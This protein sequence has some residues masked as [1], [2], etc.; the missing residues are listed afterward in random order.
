MG[1]LNCLS[2][3]LLQEGWTKDQIPPGCCGEWKDY[4]GGWEYDGKTAAAMT[5]ET[6]CGLLVNSAHWMNGH[7]AFMGMEWT[8]EN[9]NPT[10]TCPRFLPGPCPMNHPLLQGQALM[11]GVER[12]TICACHR[13]ERPYTYEGSVDEA[14]DQVWAEADRLFEEFDRAKGGRACKQQSRYNR[15]TRQ[16]RMEYDPQ[17]C[18][19]LGV[20]RWCKVLQTEISPKK[21]NVFYD[22]KT[23]WTEP[24]EG[25]FQ[26]E[27][28]TMV[29]KG[30]KL[31]EKP[32]SMTL[33][34]AI[35]KYGRHRV[36]RNYHL[37]RHNELFCNPTVKIEL[38]NFR[39]ARMDVRDLIQD[40]QDVRDGIEVRHQADDTKA[41]KEQKRKR[42]AAAKAKKLAKLEARVLQ[43][44]PALE[45]YVLD[46]AF[47]LLGRERV[48]ELLEQWEEPKPKKAE[49]EQLSL[50]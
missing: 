20:C 12:L 46:R 10:V 8:V 31:L 50:L 32:V 15:T 2:L 11:G 6:P 36:I 25:L 1:Q 35:V 33:C 37:S 5:F 18:A 49:Y 45:S 44:G 16:W 28:R 30:I 22:L 19:R 43:D 23:T 34:E 29:T 9:G 38:Q 41:D 42:L 7:M 21:G 48:E 39:A 17:E 24:G 4:Y 26:D 3:Q 47:R 14:H 40:L 27:A 13:T